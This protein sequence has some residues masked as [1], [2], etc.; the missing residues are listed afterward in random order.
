VIINEQALCHPRLRIPSRPECRANALISDIKKV[1]Q[2]KCFAS[3]CG[4]VLYCSIFF[5]FSVISLSLGRDSR[6]KYVEAL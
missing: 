5:R 2:R 3:G 6:Q 4:C 1:A